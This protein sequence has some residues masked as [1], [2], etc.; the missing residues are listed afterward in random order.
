[1]I[2]WETRLVMIDEPDGS[3]DDEPER[4]AV[5]PVVDGGEVTA[6][7]TPPGWPDRVPPPGSAG[8]QQRA[9]SWLLDHCPADYRGYAAWQRHPLALAWVAT[10]HIDGQVAA[11]RVAYRTARVELGEEISIDGLSEVLAAIEA[12]GIRLIAA[13]RSA[14]LIEDALRGKAY[15]PRM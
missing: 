11:M 13:Q 5:G 4:V 14:Q 6:S 7:L 9:V 12:E 2:T 15:V 8:W 10:Q 1:M 3:G